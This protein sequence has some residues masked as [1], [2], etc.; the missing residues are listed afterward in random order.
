MR[1]ALLVDCY[2]P[3]RKSAAKLVQDLANEFLKRGHEVM[4]ITV[5]DTLARPFVLEETGRLRVCRV[6]TGR[7]KDANRVVRAIN[8]MRLSSRV[9]DSAADYLRAHPADL[10]VYYSPTIFF[11]RLVARLKTLWHAKAYLILR[12]IFPEWAVEAGVLRKGPIYWLFKFFERVNYA[13]ADIIAVQSPSNIA[14]LAKNGHAGRRPVEVLYNWTAGD[15]PPKRTPSYRMELGLEGKIVFF[16][17]GNIGVAQDMDNI[18]RLAGALGTDPSAHFLIVGEGSEF[19][20][21]R[22]EIGARGLGNVSLLPAVSQ[23]EYLQMLQEFDIGLISLDSRLR[24]SNIPGKLLGYLECGMPTL[25]SIN[26]GNDLG[27]LLAD[28]GSGLSSFNPDDES[29]LANARLLLDDEALR[30]RMGQ[31]ARHLLHERFHVASAATQILSF[32]DRKDK[33]T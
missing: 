2:P 15:L 27:Q 25:A 24:S 3:S 30:G 7:I 18:L 19:Q 20:R 28:S 17:G 10:I 32:A 12:D 8:E 23:T 14:Y 6:R 13:A 31:N 29:L 33:T 16:Y 4:V 22:G 1:I 9:W 21:V 26:P 5:D 11:G